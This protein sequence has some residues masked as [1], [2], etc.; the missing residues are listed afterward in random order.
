M[1]LPYIQD[2]YY[3]SEFKKSYENYYNFNVP[4]DVNI[5]I[6]SNEKIKFKLID[7]SIMNTMLNISSYHKNNTF[8]VLFLGTNYTI[9]IEDGNYTA[10]SLRDEINTLLTT[11]NISIA[12]NYDKTTNKYY[13]VTADNVVAGQLYFY[14]LN[15]ASTFGFT[16]TSYELIYPNE[17]Y[18]EDFVNML[19]Y[20]KI[21]LTT[22]LTF[23]T[24]IQHNFEKKYSANSGIKDI[25]CWF[26]RDQPPYTTIN[27]NN[28]ANNE[29][30][31]ANNN[32]KNI[33]FQIMNEYQEYI[34]DCPKCYIHFQIIIYDNTNW[35]K[36]FYSIINDIGYYL[37]SIYFKYKKNINNN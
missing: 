22:D 17:Y 12:F 35:Y 3:N 36:K 28:I 2:I 26:N 10:I 23:E 16:K 30:I 19:P 34:L 8:K 5:D 1:T 29:I 24:N 11:L 7:F 4:L 15:M 37:L 20:S 33:N 18:S 14:P 31:I 13:L 6:K 25:I 32:I 9:T 21:L 27:Y